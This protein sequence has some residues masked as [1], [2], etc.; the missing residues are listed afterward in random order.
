[1]TERKASA[2]AKTD[3]NA[4]AKTAANADFLRE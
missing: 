3:G 1:M 4:I 2:G